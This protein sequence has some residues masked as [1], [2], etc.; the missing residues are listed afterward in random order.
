M[1][2]G[3]LG[4]GLTRNSPVPNPGYSMELAVLPVVSD[5]RW[6]RDARAD[7]KPV[8]CLDKI[9]ITCYRNSDEWPMTRTRPS[10][11]VGHLDRVFPPTVCRPGL[12]VT[13]LLLPSC[14]VGPCPVPGTYVTGTM[15]WAGGTRCA[16]LCPG[17]YPT[18]CDEKKPST[19]LPNASDPA[20]LTEL[21]GVLKKHG[22]RRMAGNFGGSL[23][24][25]KGKARWIP[26]PHVDDF[27]VLSTVCAVEKSSI[28]AQRVM[29]P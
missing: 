1:I 19:G 9:V 17:E 29:D 26:N 5:G 20:R 4:T 12:L 24:R 22:S 14:S 10:L 15:P 8:E 28:P 3:S 16:P 23:V 11:D 7:I 13:Y 21:A 25:E 6:Y 18:P 2:S 27:S